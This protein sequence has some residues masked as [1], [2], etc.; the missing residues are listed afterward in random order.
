[1]TAFAVGQ[2]VTT[3]T[4][5]V[6]VDAGIPPGD[7]LFSLVVIDDQ[8]SAS[9]PARVV[10]RIVPPISPGP[11]PVTVPTPVPVRPPILQPIPR[12]GIS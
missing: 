1:M 9:Q 2:P 12:T 7:H 10:V 6:V 11:V 4:P 3:D 8:G 5:Q